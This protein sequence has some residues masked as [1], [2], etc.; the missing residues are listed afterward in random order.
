V[1]LLLLNCIEAEAPRRS[2]D[3]HVAPRLGRAFAGDWAVSHLCEATPLPSPEG[4]T[5][6]ILSG[7]ELSA[8]QRNPRDD[9]LEAM[10]RGF[11]ESERAVFGIC[12]GH[13]MIARAL[14]PERLCCRRAA[15]PEFGWKRLSLRPDPVFAGIDELIA[16]HSHYDE[17][18]DLPPP[19]RVIASTGDCA[20]QAFAYEGR[21]VWGTQ[22]HPEQTHALGRAMLQENLRTEPRAPELFVDDLDDPRALNNNDRLFA[23]FFSLGRRAFADRGAA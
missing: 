4:F 17:V 13:Q 16:V 7:S 18:F 15:T 5:H 3:E 23:N 9:A 21:P 11:V 10:I 2:F 6:L 19:F 12:Y 1:R 8:A 22:F 20:V 14:L